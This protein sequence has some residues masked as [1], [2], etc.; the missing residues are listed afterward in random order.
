[1]E[2]VIPPQDLQK[3][4]VQHLSERM[5]YYL[6]YA[7]EKKVVVIGVSLLQQVASWP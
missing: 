2:S 7:T 5:V 6:R 3:A 1:M 4:L